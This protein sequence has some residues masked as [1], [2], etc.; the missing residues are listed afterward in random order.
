MIWT[1]NPVRDYDRYDYYNAKMQSRLPVCDECG[2][3]IQEDFYYELNG[4]K[5]CDCCLL[6]YCKNNMVR[7]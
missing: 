2:E 7:I 5:V 1:G 3:P 4:E 6:D